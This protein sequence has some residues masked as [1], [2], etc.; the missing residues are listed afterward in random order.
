VHERCGSAAHITSHILLVDIP[1]SAPSLVYL[2]GLGKSVQVASFLAG[3]FYSRLVKRVLLVA[4][5]SV[6]SQWQRELEKWAS[7]TT[8]GA[9]LRLIM[10]TSSGSKSK[11]DANEA[12]LRRLL[13]SPSSGGIVLT[14]YGLLASR[15][16]M[17]GAAAFTNPA[18][19]RW[20]YGILDEGHK[21]KNPDTQLF[22]SLNG[23]P[24]AHRLLLTGTP[25]LNDLEE[26]WSLFDWTSH[27]TLLGERA[28]FRNDFAKRIMAGIAKNATL[29]ERDT[30]EALTE[31]LRR[32][33]QPYFLRREKSILTYMKWTDEAQSNDDTEIS[34]SQSTSSIP[35]SLAPPSSSS[36]SGCAKE[37]SRRL[38]A[39]VATADLALFRLSRL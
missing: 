30:G 19:A 11:K 24:I 6:L 13:T 3:A 7:A 16:D 21:I 35:S 17:F 18:I 39:H 14:T 28:A 34:V 38:V 23:I 5:V 9:G 1:F 26:M 36:P 8:T 27:G 20:D 15:S 2:Q 25:V 10:V 37:R 32:R 22:K 4:P 12:E 31:E 33:I 29:Y